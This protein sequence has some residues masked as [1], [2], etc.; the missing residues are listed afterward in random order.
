MAEATVIQ[1]VD[2]NAKNGTTKAGKPYTMSRVGLSN[3]ESVFVFNPVSIGDVLE[4]V[5]SGGYINWVHKK[6]DPKHD[7]IMKAL[8]EIYKA[9]TGGYPEKVEE[10]VVEKIVEVPKPKVE[11][12]V[13][14]P[15]EGEEV[16][17]DDIPF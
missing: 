13:I 8:R 11:P 4:S 14:H 10:H 6:T 16:P 5:E 17:L 12:D 2:D 7:E 15:V 9:I 1:I 3:S